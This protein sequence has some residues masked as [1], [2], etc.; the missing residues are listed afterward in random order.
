L[1][2]APYGKP[3][4]FDSSWSSFDD[5]STYQWSYKFQPRKRGHH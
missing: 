2:Y 4:T 5:S 1:A 3:S